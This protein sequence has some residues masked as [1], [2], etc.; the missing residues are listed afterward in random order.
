MSMPIN[1]IAIFLL[2]FINF[3]FQTVVFASGKLKKLEIVTTV[4]PITNMVQ[5]IG[6]TYINVTGLV[7]GGTDS[8][9]F[10][11]APS[12]AKTLQAADMIIVNGLDLELPFNIGKK[13]KKPKS[14]SSFMVKH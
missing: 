12:D 5:N 8:H 13:V 2:F 9:T 14:Q 3:S 7:P 10:E 4:S 6:G 11:P 1:H